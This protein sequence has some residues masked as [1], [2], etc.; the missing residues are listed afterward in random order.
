MECRR[1]YSRRRVCAAGSGIAAA[2]VTRANDQRTPNWGGEP[3][4]LDS[5][6]RSPRRDRALPEPL[7]LGFASDATPYNRGC[8]VGRYPLDLS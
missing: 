7:P 4:R 5:A 3:P 8:V 1:G 2:D 6:Y